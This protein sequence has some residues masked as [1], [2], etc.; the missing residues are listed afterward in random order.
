MPE[1]LALPIGTVLEHPCAECG[2]PM[3][4]RDSKYGLFYGCTAYPDCR[5]THGAHPDGLPLGRP[6][7]AET[8]R[9]RHQA[10]LLF[11]PFWTGPKAVMSRGA[12]YRWLQNLFGLT[13]AEAHIGN[14][15][16]DQCRTLIERLHTEPPTRPEHHHDTIATSPTG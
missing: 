12:A 4:L 11:D 10:H 3:I 16:A 13:E 15:T 5:G 6:G 8:K 9:L 7:N 1:S 2:A 14:F